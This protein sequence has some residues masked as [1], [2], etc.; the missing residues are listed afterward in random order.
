MIFMAEKDEKVGK[1]VSLAEAL[2]ILEEREKDG[3]FGYEQTLAL[4]YAKKFSK[5]NTKGADSL[6]KK[7]EEIGISHKIAVSITNI[8]PL[9]VI[10][11]KQILANEK[12]EMDP[13]V[14]DKAFSL[15]EE[16]RSKG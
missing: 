15:V 16:N 2:E 6:R 3:E 11:V 10:Q 1:I 14:A 7:L 5:I 13:A 8:M 12:K 4:D 9:D